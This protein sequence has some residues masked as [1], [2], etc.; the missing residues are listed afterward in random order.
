MGWL[1]P[2]DFMM[3]QQSADD[4]RVYAGFLQKHV[5]FSH[6]FWMGVFPVTQGEY[7]A[8]TGCSPSR[9]T[10]CPSI[11]RLTADEA[12]SAA[13]LLDGGRSRLPVEQVSR[14]EATAFCARVTANERAEG[15]LPPGLCYALPTEA[16]WEYACRATTTGASYAPLDEIAWYEWTSV[17]PQ[18]YPVGLKRPNAFG[19]YDML[20]NV[21]EW[22]AGESYMVVARGGSWKSEPSQCRFGGTTVSS[23]ANLRADT[24][25]FRLALVPCPE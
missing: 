6:G 25:G 8:V 11:D 17:P 20:G 3:G 13:V 7:E 9:F 24:I 5:R 4:G 19:L 16:Q 18:T 1:P 22:C 12:L 21:E 23:H 15:R 2:G 10:A 14:T